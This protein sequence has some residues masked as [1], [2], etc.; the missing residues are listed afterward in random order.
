MESSQQ[1]LSG[2]LQVSRP[3][4]LA[5]AGSDSGGEAGIQADLQTFVDFRVHGL[6]AI[7]ANTAQSPEKIL[8]IN[9]VNHRA[10]AEQ[11]NISLEY[12]Q[13]SHIKTG[14]ISDLD[15]L[16]AIY[17]NIERQALI[18]DPIL[19]A[20][21]GASFCN[22]EMFHFYHN[23]FLDRISLLT[24]NWPEL[25]WLTN[26]PIKNKDN[27]LKAAQS[28]SKKH[29]LDIFLKG[30]HSPEPNTD[31]FINKNTTIKYSGE[32]IQAKSSHGTGC[33]ISSG[34][35]AALSLGHT[36]QRAC[37]LAKNYVLHSLK[38]NAYSNN[39]WVMQSPG[40]AENLKMLI[41]YEEINL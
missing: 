31:Y 32:L 20:S 33:R 4:C 13:P 2:H 8:S 26:L 39:H 37:Q 29:D 9:K 28:L 41:S 1:K 19:K 5:I 21:S 7:T 3:A 10:L 30:G 34:I 12:F 14:L 23:T 17:A 24:P 36:P 15:Q 11:I 22:E 6:S 40:P 38:N 25:S 27:A 35:C 16:Q 18:T